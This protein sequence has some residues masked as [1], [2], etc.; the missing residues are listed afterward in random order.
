MSNEQDAPP[1]RVGTAV[2]PQQVV[3]G[4]IGPDG[5]FFLDCPDDEMVGRG[6]MN[7]LMHELDRYYANKRAAKMMAQA[8]QTQ[9]LN[10][11]LVEEQ[12]VIDKRL[13]GR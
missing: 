7:L 9:I 12:R 13:R 8:H 5:N 4:G 10:G 6:L 3:A 11:M 1:T 2:T